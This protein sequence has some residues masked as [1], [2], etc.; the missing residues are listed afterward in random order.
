MRYLAVLLCVGLFAL[1]AFAGSI[2]DNV[3]KLNLP[4]DTLLAIGETLFNTEGANT[5]LRCHGKGGHGGDQAGAA[6]LRHPRTW[7]SYQA[8]GGDAAFAADKDKF[9][10]DME[11]SLLYLI[12]N[13]ATSWNQKFSKKHKD[14]KYDWSKV[15]IPDKAD[16]YNNMMQG[17]TS[18]PMKKQVIGL[19]KQL[20]L[21]KTN[22][23]KDVAALAAL[24]YVKTFDDGSEKGGV[25]K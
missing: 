2:A 5:C 20:K 3:A 1:P 16:K 23:A 25:F 21:K 12:R 10:Q 7:R 19:K 18:G 8:L 13:G 4:Q 17:V 24:T 11:T 22:P 9:R 6:D 14:I 15:M